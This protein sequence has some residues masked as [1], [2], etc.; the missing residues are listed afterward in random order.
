[1]KTRPLFEVKGGFS[2]PSPARDVVEDGPLPLAIEQDVAWWEKSGKCAGPSV[3]SAVHVHKAIRGDDLWLLVSDGVLV[4]KSR[5]WILRVG[6][7]QV[8]GKVIGSMHSEFGV[9]GVGGGALAAGVEGLV[10]VFDMNIVLKIGRS[11]LIAVRVAAG[12]IGGRGRVVGDQVA[13]LVY[14]S[15]NRCAG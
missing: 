5:S 3:G 13:A 4:N 14:F 2:E 11:I 7:D 15:D 1:M 8:A 12:R 6:V 9:G 10:L